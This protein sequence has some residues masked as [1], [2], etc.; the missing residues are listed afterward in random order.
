MGDIIL[1]LFID[2]GLIDGFVPE[3]KGLAVVLDWALVGF[4]AGLAASRAV[5]AVDA[6]VSLLIAARTRAWRV[7]SRTAEVARAAL[8]VEGRRG[9]RGRGG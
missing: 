8:L 4:V 3:T 6:P 2:K 1:I 7:T 5:A 9:R